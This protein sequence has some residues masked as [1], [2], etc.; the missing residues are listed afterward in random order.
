M[1]PQMIKNNAPE[2]VGEEVEEEKDSKNE[3]SIDEF[4]TPKK[5]PALAVIDKLLFYS[6]CTPG[7]DDDKEA[8]QKKVEK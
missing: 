1:L 5:N 3:E 6:P 8:K 4:K 7:T 2:T